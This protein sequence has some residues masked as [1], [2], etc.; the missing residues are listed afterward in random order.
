MK[1]QTQLSDLHQKY[2]QKEITKK[3]FEEY[4]FKYLLNNHEHLNP[5]KGNEERFMDFLSLLYPRI[6]RAVDSYR[7]TGASFE[8]YLAS[9][10]HWSQK[11]YKTRESDHFII[12]Y[13][14]WKAR[15]EEISSENPEPGYVETEI[16]L[17]PY[18]VLENY[19]RRQSLILFLKS[20]YFVS[21]DLLRRVAKILEMRQEDLWALVEQLRA[22]RMKHER[23]VSELKA[24][25][26]GQYYRCLAF[27]NRIAA[28]PLES[29]LYEKLK[30]SY[31]KATHR[32]QNMKKRLAGFKVDVSNRQIAEILNLSKG[33]IDST[34]HVIH[35]KAKRL[36]TNQPTPPQSGQDMVVL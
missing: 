11:D 3:E 13:S 5:F 23:A 22:R 29:A 4:I 14:C 34:L 17:S 15:A 21:E 28:A 1:K 31:E 24:R 26:H 30:K 12:E 6:S 32:L 16:D 2:V 8:A 25:I 7:D 35:E 36:G 10:I 27:Q 33:T 9:I 18:E 19:T 20:Y